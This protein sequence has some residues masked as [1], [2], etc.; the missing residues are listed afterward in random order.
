LAEIDMSTREGMYQWSV[1]YKKLQAAMDLSLKK[2]S[3]AVR[4]IR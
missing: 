1:A 4:M 2:Y 3:D